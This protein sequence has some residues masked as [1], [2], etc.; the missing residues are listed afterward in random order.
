[1]F[2]V[3]FGLN[4]LSYKLVVYCQDESEQIRRLMLRNKKLSENDA[5]LRIESQ[6]S[7]SQRLK[8]A[9]YTI[10]NSKTIDVTRRQIKGLNEIFKKFKKIHFNKTRVSFI[11]LSFFK[12]RYFDS[13]ITFD[14]L[15]I[16]T[17]QKL[18]KICNRVIRY[19]IFSPF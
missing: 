15:K 10:D 17:K 11:W 1:M 5:K 14:F 8:L 3:K 18:N 19:K 13:F 9:D 4:L 6:M 2:E 16:L 12:W 7:A